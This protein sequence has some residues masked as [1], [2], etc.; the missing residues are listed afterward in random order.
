MA[1]HRVS[2]EIQSLAS[3]SK[4][5]DGDF[6][7]ADS[8]EEEKDTFHLKKTAT[9]AAAPIP[10][11]APIKGGEDD[12]IRFSH[13][14]SIQVKEATMD[15]IHRRGASPPPPEK[16]LG[17][18]GKRSTGGTAST[19]NHSEDVD[20]TETSDCLPMDVIT[21]SPY[22]PN[23]DAE[24]GLKVF[25]DMKNLLAESDDDNYR[26]VDPKATKIFGPT[27]AW[28][29]VKANGKVTKVCNKSLNYV[30]S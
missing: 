19:R 30:E 9:I 26:S 2:S 17:R 10:N 20:E 21:K 18:G 5:S 13:V 6:S 29:L 4:S 12:V 27:N 14:A 15:P 28:C 8:S 7:Q 3:H 11:H 1:Q 23:Y 24:K 16:V 25:A 22:E